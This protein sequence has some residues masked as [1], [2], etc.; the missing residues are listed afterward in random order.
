MKQ[1]L[2]ITEPHF[3]AICESSLVF[4]VAVQEL[5]QLH[6]LFLRG[7]YQLIDLAL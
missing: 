2:S 1:T 3:R 7:N 4:S 5:N 6:R